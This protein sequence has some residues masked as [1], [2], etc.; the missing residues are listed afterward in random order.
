MY[1]IV[2]LC[3]PEPMCGVVWYI[4]CELSCVCE[5]IVRYSILECA[6]MCICRYVTVYI[7]ML[8]TKS[9]CMS[10]RSFACVLTIKGCVGFE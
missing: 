7:G 9:R 4:T 6:C 10:A 8:G 5:G 1:D 3:W 2:C